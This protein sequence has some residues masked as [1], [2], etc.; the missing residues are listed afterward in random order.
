MYLLTQEINL[1]TGRVTS[2]GSSTVKKCSEIDFLVLVVFLSPFMLINVKRRQEA[3]QKGGRKHVQKLAGSF[4]FF[5]VS[6]NV[7]GTCSGDETGTYLKT[8]I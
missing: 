7:G 6:C 2:R 5:L 4:L 1:P 3:V 8:N